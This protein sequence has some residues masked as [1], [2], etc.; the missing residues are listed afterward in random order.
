MVLLTFLASCLAVS[1]FV[2]CYLYFELQKVE[3]RISSTFTFTWGSNVQYITPYT[4][5]L[6]M[7]FSS[8]DQNISIRAR[9]NDDDYAAG[10]YLGLV[11]DKNA[12]GSVD[13][14]EF[15]YGL[16]ANNKSYD[17]A[18]L[19]PAGNLCFPQIPPKP[20]PYHTATFNSQ[21]G[22]TFEI[23]LP[24]LNLTNSKVHVVFNDVNLSMRLCYTFVYV[25]F[26]F[27]AWE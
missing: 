25:Q 17:N 3:E 18:I 8:E 16:W 11:F 12:D 19:S 4:L 14:K 13:L 1:L 2:N 10:D 26:M 22:Y 23:K 6:E 21:T 27:E 7:Q 5:K 9:I 24:K 20:S 15:G